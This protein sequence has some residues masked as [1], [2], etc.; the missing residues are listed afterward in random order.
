[1]K[2]FVITA[3]ILEV[4]DLTAVFFF[5]FFVVCFSTIVLFIE[6]YKD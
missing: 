3:H 4:V 5:G 1:M 2:K 6:K